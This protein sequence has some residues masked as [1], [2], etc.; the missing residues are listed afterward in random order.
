MT[1]P[2]PEQHRQ[3]AEH[4]QRTFG[5]LSRVQA[6]VR[7]NTGTAAAFDQQRAI[8][9]GALVRAAQAAKKLGRDLDLTELSQSALA[10]W[11]WHRYRREC[12]R[13]FQRH[14]AREVLRLKH[15]TLESLLWFLATEP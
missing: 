9:K 4:L 6:E 12:Y 10:G 2:L 14:E 15:P 1:Q 5:F 7:G 8:C 13:V 11:F 3:H